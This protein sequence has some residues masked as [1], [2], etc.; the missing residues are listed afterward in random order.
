MIFVA[1]LTAVIDLEGEGILQTFY[2]TTG[3]G[4]ITKPSDSPANTNVYPR[5]LDP[6]T[7]SRALFS[8]SKVFGAVRPSFGSVVI[9]NPDGLFDIWKTY[10]FDGQSFILRI[11]EEGGDYPSSFS[12]VFKCTMTSI[13]LTERDV[14]V[15]LSDRLSMLDKPVLNRPLLGTGGV[16]GTSD[17]T[18]EM[19]PRA[20]GDPGW[21]PLK[22]LDN[23]ALIYAIQTE[24]TG[25]FS[26]YVDIYDGGVEIVR[27]ADYS[28]ISDLL[29]NPP[30]AGKC[31]IYPAGPVYLRLG[32]SPTYELRTY[33]LGY[34]ANS[35]F[36]TYADL[37]IE[38]G[39]TDAVIESSLPVRG[40]YVD[41]ASTTYMDVLDESCKVSL[42][43]Y[44]FDRLDVFRSGYV[45]PTLTPP[46]Y[47]FNRN[48]CISISRT[49]PDFQ[50][51]PTYKLTISSGQ[52]WP[53]Q[54]AEGA[55]TQM[56]DYL[57]RQNW[58]STSSYQDDS[59]LNKHK[60]AKSDIVEMKY[61]IPHSFEFDG[62]R[63]SYMA[64]FGV[65]REQV[66]I[67]CLLTEENCSALLSLDIMSSVEV[68][69][70]RFGFDAGKT[71]K[72]I[73]MTYKLSSNRL[74][75]ILWG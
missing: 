10:G 47:S 57:T 18:G 14:T 72:I 7:Y 46:V 36:Y 63:A 38:A 67:E 3:N 55:T 6:G 73:S 71:F 30:S 25:S 4:F 33:T 62:I 22:L 74:E 16:E 26:E 54:V 59:I 19:L 60:L 48:N 65:E 41:D 9:S 70:P 75:F 49:S 52:T 32:T 40:L 43:Y 29:A 28:S 44:G 50:E 34:K 15:N 69:M 42:S 20:F 51:V 58:F 56:K 8:G 66:M 23:S 12:T 68:K 35:T 2:I 61:R 39:V 64:L 13:K 11:G 27:E 5:L 24:S 1:E 45:V 53:C 17:M 31:R 37:A 21:V